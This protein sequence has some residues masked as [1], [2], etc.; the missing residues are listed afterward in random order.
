M[1]KAIFQMEHNKAPGS[2]GFPAE[3]YQVFWE[4]IKEDLI[5]MFSDFH[6]NT[7]LIY[8]LNFGV[9]TLIPKKCNAMKI[10]EYRPICLLNVS[11]KVITKV[12][13]R[14][15]GSIADK[16]I[17][18]SQTSFMPCRNILEGVTVLHEMIHE[19]HKKTIDGVIIK[20]DF[21]KAYDKVKWNFL[22]QELCIKG[23]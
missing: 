11:F 18:P 17:R 14:Q 3:F 23:F 5:A 16:I 19:L 15:I 13:T 1:H 12:L 22:Q 21:E 7:L 4:L 10:Q 20:L 6:D 8:S 2:D 9:I